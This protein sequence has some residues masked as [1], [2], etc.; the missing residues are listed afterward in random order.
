MYLRGTSGIF[1]R[2]ELNPVR[3]GLAASPEGYLWSSAAAHM[4]GRDDVMVRVSALPEMV[5]DWGEFLSQEVAQEDVRLLRSHKR[6]GRPLGG[7]GFID[8]L[9]TATGRVLRRLKPG[10]KARQKKE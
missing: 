6:T 1:L 10:R 9:E 4:A 3:A 8:R 2:L 7:K 5:G